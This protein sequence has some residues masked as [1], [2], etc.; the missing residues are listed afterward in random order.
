MADLATL[1][2]QLEELRAKRASGVSRI[3]FVSPVTS[4]SMEY[5]SDGELA[6]AIADIE[7]QIAAHTASAAPKIVYFNTSKG[8]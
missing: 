4:R 8:L 3:S 5:R 1:Q 2:A 7:R 6:A